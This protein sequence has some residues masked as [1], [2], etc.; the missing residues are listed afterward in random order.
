MELLAYSG[1]ITLIILWILV[2]VPSTLA[3]V[4]LKK[5]AMSLAG[6]HPVYGKYYNLGLIAFPPA[7]ISFFLYLLGVMKIAYIPLG[8]FVF[9]FGGVCSVAG[10]LITLRRSRKIH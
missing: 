7:A 5:R 8:V 3:H 9:L 4:N 10:G 1:I 2:V 6:D